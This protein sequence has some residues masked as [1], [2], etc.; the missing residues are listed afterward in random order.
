MGLFNRLG[1]RVEELKQEATSASKES[2]SH[3]CEACETS[4][5][6][7][8]DECPECGERAVVAVDAD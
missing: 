4:L 2:A 5:Y 3:W 8:H 7:G 6:T 1:R